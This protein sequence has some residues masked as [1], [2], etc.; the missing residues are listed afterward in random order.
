MRWA[1]ISGDGLPVS[2][3]LTV[4]RNVVD[5]AA[6]AIDFPVGAD[7]GYSWRPDKPAF[8]PR[9]PRDAR[10]PDWLR[11]RDD[12]PV[13]TKEWGDLRVEVARADRSDPAER[14]A[15]RQR[16]EELAEP[17]EEHFARWFAED[18]VDWA[19]AINLTLSDAPPV[20]LALHR[21]A[22]RHWS[23]GR[24]GGVLYW[25]HDLFGTCAI[26]EHGARVYPP[27][28]NEFT[29]LP[30]TSPADRWA[31]VSA[32]QER[33]TRDYP[34]PLR[35]EVLTNV[36]PVVPDGP[37]EQAHREFLR[38]HDLE[39]RP[40]VLVPV[41]VFPVKG[42]EI[43]VEVF[44]GLRAECARTGAPDPALLVF[45]SPDEDPDYAEVVAR[46]V[47]DHHVA[48]AVTF[49][50]GVPISSHTDE[51]GTW[52]PDEI[53][54]LRLARDTGGAVLFTPSRTDV[55]TVGLGPALAALAG[56]PCAVTPYDAFAEHFGPDFAHVS[57]DPRRAHDA[58][59][60]LAARMA[61]LRAGDHRARDDARANLDRVRKRFPDRPWVDFLARM[62]A[63]TS[64]TR[65]PR[66]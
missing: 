33:E 32:L 58:G 8:F 42:V 23:G 9:G 19:V 20:T 53:D 16:I 46:A 66:V 50:G 24:P 13:L 63:Q 27:R 59:V 25:D 10:Y 43:A 60:V 64:S 48:D 31:V 21:A 47:A 38:H 65:R 61:A 40:V 12:V 54:L 17:Y 55:E 51:S 36:L 56:I 52:R 37:L 35:P 22:A 15:L 2:G 6:G 34:T 4:F 62:T 18:D 7:L 44:A 29:P 26:H 5:R 1:L 41:R 3:L 11:V 14:A 49:L 39:G 30:G 45:G 57:V 28:P